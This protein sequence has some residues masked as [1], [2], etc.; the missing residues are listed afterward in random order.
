M[1]VLLAAGLVLIGLMLV[2][3]ED[4]D[5]DRDEGAAIS[6]RLPGS[7]IVL[8]QGMTDDQVMSAFYPGAVALDTRAGTG[9]MA[10]VKAAFGDYIVTLTSVNHALKGFAVGPADAGTSRTTDALR[11]W[12]E[13]GIKRL[14]SPVHK[15]RT[16][17]LGIPFETWGTPEI[18][19]GV[20]T[21]TDKPSNI[22]HP[23]YHVTFT[24]A[25]VDD[26]D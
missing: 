11:V 15:S 24:A 19:W 22:R 17:E 10:N 7:K 4:K 13:T 5:R 8:S 26:D 16:N 1:R 14:K 23:V 18:E 25:P 20:W 2:H 12:F 6:V 9:G 3:A 21:V